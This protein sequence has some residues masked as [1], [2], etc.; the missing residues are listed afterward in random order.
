MV[1]RSG[2]GPENVGRRRWLAV[3]A[4]GSSLLALGSAAALLR[5]TG[6]D[7]TPSEAAR[8]RTLSAADYALVRS[9]ARRLVAPDVG[10]APLADEVGVAW[11]VD[12]YAGGLRARLLRDFLHMLRFTEQV[13]PLSCGYLRRFTSLEAAQQDRVLARLESSSID[14]VRAGFQALKGVVMMGYYRDPRSFQILEYGGPL[15]APREPSP[16]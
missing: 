11:F 5:T 15:L 3:S 2:E 13:A 6:Y 1:E 7:V 14:D 12:R 4:L 10:A 16:P 9:L 8:L